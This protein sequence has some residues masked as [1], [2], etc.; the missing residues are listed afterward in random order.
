MVGG[1][2]QGFLPDAPASL[3][4]PRRPSPLRVTQHIDVGVSRHI[5]GAKDRHLPW[6]A[7]RWPDLG[8]EP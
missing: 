2:T 4:A 3:P 7:G 1:G 8:T 5:M 6:T